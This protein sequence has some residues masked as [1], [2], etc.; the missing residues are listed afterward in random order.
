MQK[1]RRLPALLLAVVMMLLVMTGCG[2]STPD[3]KSQCIYRVNQARIASGSHSLSHDSDLD[4]NAKLC[5][6]WYID[7]LDGKFSK[8]DVWNER[9]EVL[10][11]PV[12]SGHTTV[13]YTYIDFYDIDLDD[14]YKGNYTFSQ[15]NEIRT[16]KGE[17]I[18]LYE[19]E[20]KGKMRVCITIVDMYK[21]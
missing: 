10:N 6:E 4:E 15:N 9:N 17:F 5:M 8:Q 20:Y 13:K 14:Y 7:Y 2:E 21:S 3:G 19:K 16:A 1:I 18:G 11:V 12:T